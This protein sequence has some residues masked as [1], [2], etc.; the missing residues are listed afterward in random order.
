MMSCR[1]NSCFNT[2]LFQYDVETTLLLPCVRCWFK[3]V[4]IE[5]DMGSIY[6]SVT[7]GWG[8]GE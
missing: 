6:C 5:R 1:N 2:M 8:E 3:L 7:E 4:K